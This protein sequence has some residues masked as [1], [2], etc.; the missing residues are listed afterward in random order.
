MG[1]ERHDPMASNALV[2]GKHDAQTVDRVSHVIGQVEVVADPGEQ[3]GLFTPTECEVIGLIVH[4]GL[5]TLPTKEHDE[6]Q[7][8]KF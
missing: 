4:A 3:E 6:R 8:L 1:L 5:V 2:R 7:H